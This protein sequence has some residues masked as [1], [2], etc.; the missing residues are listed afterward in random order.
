MIRLSPEFLRVKTMLNPT[1]TQKRSDNK[2]TIDDRAKKL[3]GVIYDEKEK[4]EPEDNEPKIKVSTLIS[5]MAF[6][7]EK[8]RNSVDYKDEHL[9]RKY[10]IERI[11]KR[12]LVIQG[13]IEKGRSEEVARHLLTELIRADYLPNNKIPESKIFEIS[14]VINKYV[15]LKIY[16]PQ[17]KDKK[18]NN[19]TDW[20]IG[21]AASE[22]EERLG[23]SEISETLVNYMFEVL[24]KNIVVTDPAYAKDKEIQ[25]YVGINRN[26]FRFDRNMM[27]FILFKYFNEGWSEAGDEEIKTIARDIYSI[28]AAIDYQIDHP[29]SKRLDRIIMRYTVIFSVLSEVIE[30]DPIGA[31][32][33]LKSDVPEFEKTIKAVCEKKYK[34]TRSKLWG[35]ALRS[36]IYIFL[37]KMIVAIILEVPATQLLGQT[38]NAISLAI[39]IG[40]PPFLLF[41]IVLF[42]RVPSNEN[43]KKVIEGIKEVVYIE[44]EKKE[45]YKVRPFLKKSGSLNTFFGILYAVTFFASF[46]IVVWVLGQINFNFISTILFLFFLTLVSFFGLRIRKRVR[47]LHVIEPKENILGLLGDFFYTPVIAVGKWLSEKFSRMNV[48]VFVLDFIIEAPFKIFVEVTEEWAKYVKERREELD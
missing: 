41:L 42:T 37:T 8:I 20:I 30:A 2:L 36:I 39:N 14:R 43:T 26:F 5:K 21:L 23:R 35:A 32:N 16:S 45:P 10:S 1:L 44:A 17:D 4:I 11:L 19:L 33:K 38:V 24:G 9:L 31:Y 6:F 3:F 40:F 22:I 13:A 28:R 46:G 7:Y 27:E 48:L 12:Q 18:N 25:I 34:K 47:E 15:K 29:I